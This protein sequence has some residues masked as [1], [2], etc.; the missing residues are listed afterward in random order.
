MTDT[1]DSQH[2]A[3]SLTSHNKREQSFTHTNDKSQFN[4]LL[5]SIHSIKFDMHKTNHGLLDIKIHLIASPRALVIMSGFIGII[6]VVVK[7][8]GH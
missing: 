5:N 6:V 4:D 7:L 8:L 3:K 1:N 2:K